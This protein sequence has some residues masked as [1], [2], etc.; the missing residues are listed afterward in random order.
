MISQTYV[1][2]L[3]PCINYQISLRKQ[4]VPDNDDERCLLLQSKNN[5]A[6][7]EKM[8]GPFLKDVACDVVCPFLKDYCALIIFKTIKGKFNHLLNNFIF[9]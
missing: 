3:D 9:S 8:L 1:A 7:S 5:I 6:L 2:K 4:L